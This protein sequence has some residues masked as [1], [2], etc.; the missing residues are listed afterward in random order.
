MIE[1]QRLVPFTTG[2]CVTVAVDTRRKCCSSSVR[3]RRR[4]V[5]GVRVAFGDVA[6]GICQCCDGVL[7]AAMVVTEAA[8]IR[9]HGGFI[10]VAR[11]DVGAGR[12]RRV[13]SAGIV[14][15]GLLV[16]LD[17]DVV[18]A[19]DSATE[20]VET[21]ADR[22]SIRRCG[23]H[24]VVLIPGEAQGVRPEACGNQGH[25][26][27]GVVGDVLAVGGQH[28]VSWA[29]RSGLNTAVF[30]DVIPVADRRQIPRLIQIAVVAIPPSE[31]VFCIVGRVVESVAAHHSRDRFGQFVLGQSKG[32]RYLFAC[33]VTFLGVSLICPPTKTGHDDQVVVPCY[34]F[35]GVSNQAKQL[36]SCLVF[37]KRYLTPF[38]LQAHLRGLTP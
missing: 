14:S 34:A 30:G 25:V 13:R 8:A 10:D 37:Q 9:S 24:T 19:C 20:G 26:A 1:T 29:V 31:T 7:L 18:V 27:F 21:L 17:V 36:A 6:V 3:D 11:V 33:L 5:R 28:F 38:L 35:D 22:S 12:K 15:N 32:V 2:V 16:D 4:T 23:T